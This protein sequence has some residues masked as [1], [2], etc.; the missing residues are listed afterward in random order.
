MFFALL[1]LSDIEQCEQIK[2]PQCLG[3][4]PSNLTQ[5]PNDELDFDTQEAAGLH[6][7]SFIPL[8]NI[9]CSQYL[10]P[11]LCGSLFPICVNESTLPLC[12]YLC[13][14]TRQG[15][16]GIMK[17]YGFD[18]IKSMRCLDLDL[19]E[20]DECLGTNGIEK[21]GKKLSPASALVCPLSWFYSF[22]GSF[23][24]FA[25]FYLL[26]EGQYSETLGTQIG[27]PTNRW[28]K[29]RW[30]QWAFVDLTFRKVYKPNLPSLSQT[31]FMDSVNAEE[32]ARCLLL[33][34]FCVSIVCW[35]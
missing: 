18:W 24:W 30:Q 12:P 22:V 35:L 9:Q 33:N 31:H 11:Y 29:G 13:A 16:E 8:L 5:F 20:H 7:H 17:K 23:R 27:T 19:E 28:L 2:Q 14:M 4:F 10:L 6:F 1:S 25:L 32:R 34:Q 15:C 3:L 21:V 26:W